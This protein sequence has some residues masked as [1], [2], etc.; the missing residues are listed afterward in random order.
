L[1]FSRVLREPL[2]HF[3]LI[4]LALFLYY[5]HV[6]P[7]DRDTR[8]IV[9][10]QAQVDDLAR[11]YQATW[12]QP[13]TPS[14]LSGLVE[15]YIHD[16]ILYREGHALGLDR[17]DSVIKRRI[18]QKLEVMSEEE[19]SHEAPTDADLSAYLQAHPDAF[20]QQAVVTFEQI[21]FGTT[22]PGADLDRRIATARRALEQGADAAQLG[23]ATLLP[24]HMDGIALD[25]IAREFGEA[26][27]KQLLAAP[28][29]QWTGPLT[30]GFGAHLVRVK[31]L[32]P[33]ELPPLQAVRTAVAREWEDDQRR[34]VLDD[35]Y[36]K[37]RQSYDVV[38]EAKLPAGSPP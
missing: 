6:A 1:N 21:F 16:E 24:G 30:S 8:R 11:Q 25:S 22:G 32:K 14:E 13:P 28:V 20:R 27:A 12:N 31:A 7:G 10:S 2:L 36:R 18:R 26:F 15:A 17:D 33:P 35:N 9:V 5:G 4:G 23:Q 29:G 34:R 38:F 19:I 37:L 3:L